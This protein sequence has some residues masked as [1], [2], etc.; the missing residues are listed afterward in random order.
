METHL[1]VVKPFDGLARGDMIFDRARITAVLSGEHARFVVR[2]A[3]QKS[4]KG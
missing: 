3:S 2:V 4:G 1:V